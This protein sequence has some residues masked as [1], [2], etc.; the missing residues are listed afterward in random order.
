MEGYLPPIQKP[1][2]SRQ[3]YGTPEDFLSAVKGRLGIAEFSVDLAAS[4]SNAVADEFFDEK[5]DGL[6][7]EW[8]K[9]GVCFLNPPFAR[10]EPWVKKAYRE[11]RRGV[12]VAV[13]VPAGVGSNWWAK[14]VHGKACVLLLNGR[15]T[16]VGE[17]APYPKDCVLLL[18]GP[19]IAPGYDV[20]QWAVKGEKREAA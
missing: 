6:A 11:S 17:T 18:Y 20:W 2:R 12:R 1:G 3:D 19:D 7:Q 15:I 4:E 16:F 14:W 9:Y 10:I 13:L 8:P 5:S